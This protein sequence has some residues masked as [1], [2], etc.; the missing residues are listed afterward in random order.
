[1]APPASME[2]SNGEYQFSTPEGIP[3]WDLLMT[4]MSHHIQ[5]FHLTP[6]AVQPDAQAQG[7]A[8]PRAEKVPRPQ[9]KLGIGQDEFSYF[10]DEWTSYKR[11]CGITDETGI[12]SV[13]HATRTSEEASSTALVPSWKPS[14]SS[15]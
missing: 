4:C 11:S 6:A 5:A 9:I 1:M 3:T 12:N 8:K 7:H 10:K 14:Q 13:Q 15:R 2:C